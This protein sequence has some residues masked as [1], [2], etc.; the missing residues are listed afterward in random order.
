MRFVCL[1]A[2][3]L[4]C[5][6]RELPPP[7]EKPDPSRHGIELTWPILHEVDG[8]GESVQAFRDEDTGRTHFLA[9]VAECRLRVKPDRRFRYAWRRGEG[10]WAVIEGRWEPFEGG[11]QLRPDA[12]REALAVDTGRLTRSYSMRNDPRVLA[13]LGVE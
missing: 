2:L 7:L 5:G 1:L 3:L 13:H 6:R 11:W 12:G 9:T 10:E 8:P 4:A